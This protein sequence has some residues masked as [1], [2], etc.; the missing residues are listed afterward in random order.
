MSQDQ[1]YQYAALANDFFLIHAPAIMNPYVSVL[2]FLSVS[3][4]LFQQYINGRQHRKLSEKTIPS[5][6]RKIVKPEEFEKARLYSLDKS[7]FSFV[8]ELF[9][10]LNLLYFVFQWYP[11]IW[12]FSGEAALKYLGAKTEIYQSLIYLGIMVVIGKIQAL[13]FELYSTFVIERKHGFNKQTVGLFISDTLKGFLLQGILGGPFVAAFIWVVRRFGDNFYL[14]VWLLVFCFQMFVMLI[15]PTFIQPLFN[16]F[17][18]LPEGSL[19][20]KIEAL[21]RKLTFPLSQ[22][23]VMDGSKRSSHSNAYFFGF[24]TK[25]IVLFDTLIQQ[26]S[27]DEICAVLGHELGHWKCWHQFQMLFVTQLHIFALFY[28]FSHFINRAEIYEAFGFGKQMPVII[29]LMLFGGFSA[30]SE[31]LL[32]FL[33]NLFSRKNEFE[34]DRFAVNLGYGDLLQSALVNLQIENKSNMNPDWMYS[35]MNYS[36]PPLIERLDAIKVAMDKQK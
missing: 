26:N 5:K 6:I 16:K 10:L 34:A 3:I 15:F 13:P 12:D 32:S 8:S 31:I 29:G 28:A 20:T 30:P 36:H 21:A 35:A 22:I 33:M 4:F 14:A 23:F 11:K 7:T 9:G 19:R 1:L 24:F 25:R 18:S 17:E 27:E 2:I